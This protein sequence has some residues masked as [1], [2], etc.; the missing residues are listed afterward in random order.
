MDTAELQAQLDRFRDDFDTL[1]REIGRVIV[2]QDEIVRGTLI[3]L[4][5]GGERRAR[6]LLRSG[7]QTRTCTE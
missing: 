1:R 5:S 6:C 2:G 4:L 7:R 3:S